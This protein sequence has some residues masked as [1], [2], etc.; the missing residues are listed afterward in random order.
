MTNN[1]QSQ[2]NKHHVD[3]QQPERGIQYNTSEKDGTNN[4][5]NQSIQENIRRETPIST[6]NR[7]VWRAITD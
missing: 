5:R 3:V 2:E 4:N 6:S 1:H 7:M